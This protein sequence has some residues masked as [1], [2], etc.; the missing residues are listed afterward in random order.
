MRDVYVSEGLAG[1]ETREEYVC[2]LKVLV[3]AVFGSSELFYM[4]RFMGI[5]AT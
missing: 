5:S 3:T 2:V 4:L 1:I